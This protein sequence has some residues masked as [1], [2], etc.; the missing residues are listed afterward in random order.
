MHRVYKATEHRYAI[1]DVIC[2]FIL[3]YAHD[4]YID[5]LNDLPYL[6]NNE[7]QFVA[8]AIGPRATEEGLRDLAFFHTEYPRNGGIAIFKRGHF[9]EILM[10][11]CFYFFR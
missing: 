10:F 2:M 6:V 9:S 7:T 11:D 4:N 8:W 3:Y 1:V 5:D